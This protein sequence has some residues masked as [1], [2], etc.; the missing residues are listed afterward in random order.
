MSNSLRP[1]GL[2]SAR[3]LCPWDSQARILEWVAISSCRQ[4]SQSRD[5][6]YIS[7]VSCIGRWVLYHCAT[8]KDPACLWLPCNRAKI[9][10]REAIPCLTPGKT[11]SVTGDCSQCWDC[12]VRR[13]SVL[14][15]D[16][17]RKTQGSCCR[18][19]WT[20]QGGKERTVKKQ[21]ALY[22]GIGVLYEKGSISNLWWKKK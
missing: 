5:Q 11:E 17:P 10:G 19:N 15:D 4:S 8:W 6:T 21:T 7:G 22:A 2:S 9:T 20:E 12:S 1:Y 16:Q 13:D 3:L 14:A 18:K